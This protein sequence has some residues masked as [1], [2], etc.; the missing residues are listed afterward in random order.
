MSPSF[1]PAAQEQS[2][3]QVQQG[4][5]TQGRERLRE[6]CFWWPERLESL[7][8]LGSAQ[9]SH[10]GGV[11]LD[12]SPP[13][14]GAPCCLLMHCTIWPR[15]P[16]MEFSKAGWAPCPRMGRIPGLPNSHPPTVKPITEPPSSAL[17]GRLA[18]Q[19]F[20]LCSHCCPCFSSSIFLA[21]IRTKAFHDL[22]C[23]CLR[24]Q[25]E[26]CTED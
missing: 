23:I 20:F 3:E 15:G 26:G 10:P 1:I 16:W 24:L 22:L 21:H 7:L 18:Q 6:A 8:G 25:R 4:L 11:G 14:P 19:P 13:I 17:W 5:K 9:P 12:C 2:Q